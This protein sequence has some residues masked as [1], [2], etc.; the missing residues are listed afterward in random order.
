M[1]D[2]LIY[3]D[4]KFSKYINQAKNLV[5]Q[6]SVA[7]M[8]GGM[9]QAEVFTIENDELVPTGYNQYY[10]ISQFNEAEGLKILEGVSDK[11]FASRK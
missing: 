2:N 10:P 3:R 9:W 4:Y 7:T 5:A 6:V 1:M 8:G 11:Y